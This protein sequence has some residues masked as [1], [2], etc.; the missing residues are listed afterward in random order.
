[1]NNVVWMP[2]AASATLTVAAPVPSPE[3]VAFETKCFEAVRAR[4]VSRGFVDDYVGR[5]QKLARR[6]MGWAGKRLWEL[7]ESDF[8]A[9]CEDLAKRSGIKRSTQRS[10][11][12]GVCQ[13]FKILHAK[14]EIQN[15]SFRL[16]G[17][18]IDRVAHKDNCLVHAVDNESEDGRVAM[19][20][21]EI[22]RFFALLDREIAIAVVEHPREVRAL[23]RDKVLFFAT[24]VY[25]LRISECRGL[26][27]D[28]WSAVHYLPEMGEYGA[29]RVIGK[30]AKGS[31]PRPRSIPT[32]HP[33]LPEL[34]A[35][36]LKHVRP[37]YTPKSGHEQALFFSE[38]GAR[39]SK[40]SIE[41]R[42]KE[43][44]TRAGLPADKLVPHCLRHT[45]ITHEVM[46]S[47]AEFARNKAGQKSIA[48][49]MG[50]VHIPEEH[51]QQTVRRLVNA[52]V[53]ALLP[54]EAGP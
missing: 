8:E 12:S 45:M 17:Q 46:R 32:D 21:E 49:T 16:F 18:R 38:R 33:G 40:Q 5:L 51:T 14:P 41:S 6:L 28:S 54:K 7:T 4:L 26:N 19:T 30:G 9:W 2:V 48:V 1:M 13:F 50:Y 44:I 31:G 22:D 15:E 36:Y 25:G 3:A 39:I 52:H 10:Y 43:L 29:V 53:A 42:F 35:W 37:R 23:Q 11:Q 47:S 24:Y 27:I 20:H 34:V